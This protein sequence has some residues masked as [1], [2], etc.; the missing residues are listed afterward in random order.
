MLKNSET[1]NNHFM[2]VI[3]VVMVVL[4]LLSLL[5][6]YYLDKKRVERENYLLAGERC[7]YD[8]FFNQKQKFKYSRLHKSNLEE[9][10][11]LVAW[12]TKRPIFAAKR[13]FENKNYIK[14]LSKF[15]DYKINNCKLKFREKGGLILI[16]QLA[17]ISVKN[18]LADGKCRVFK[19]F[20]TLV[21]RFNLK[22][23]EQAAFKILLLKF[24]LLSLF[25]IESEL[26]EID[27]V[28]QKSKNANSVKKYRK[29][30]LFNAEIYGIFKFN[31]NYNK[32]LF[33][34]SELAN[35]ASK[36]LFLE[37]EQIYV[38]VKL[39]IGYAKVIF[40]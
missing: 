35:S 15:V 36:L 11:N 31:S 20:N 3:I 2:A 29:L 32:L 23:R 24:L 9:Q 34:K 37:L 17:A 1:G 18:L 8:Y 28:I 7:A 14:T 27:C 19:N 16:E 38:K 25:E 21:L 4:L 5:L 30:L 40:C 39:I 12:G 26:E 6:Q 22:K 13:I 10:S 33:N